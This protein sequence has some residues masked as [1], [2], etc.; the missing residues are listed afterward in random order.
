[1]SYFAPIPDIFYEQF[2][3]DGK[4]PLAGGYIYFYEAGTL[5]PKI[6]FADGLG[7]VTNTN[8]VQLDAGG[9]AVIFLDNGAYKIIIK[10]R[11][12][13]QI[14]EPV[15]NVA[16][17]AGSGTGDAT[18]NITTVLLYAD[19]RNLTS[20][21]SNVYVQGRDTIGD[22]GQ[23]LFQLIPNS[24]LLDD[25]GTILT[26]NSGATVYKRVFDA[27]LEAAWYGVKYSIANDQYNYLNHAL[28]ASKALGYPVM[29]SGSAFLNTNMT[30]I[31]DESIAFLDGA[32]L[33]A[34]QDIVI[35]FKE[36]SHCQAS[37]NC[38]GSHIQPKFANGT[39]D[40]ISPS[41]FSGSGD[42][43]L[44]RANAAQNSTNLVVADPTGAGWGT[45]AEGK[46]IHAPYN[47]VY[48]VST[49]TGLITGNRYKLHIGIDRP[50]DV[51]FAVS[52]NITL[53]AF[54]GTWLTEYSHAA[55][56][57]VMPLLL[58]TKVPAGDATLKFNIACTAGNVT[59][60]FG[61]TVIGTYSA[62]TTYSTA[63]TALDSAS[64]TFTPS[65]TFVGS[66]SG[67]S[68][69]VSATVLNDLVNNMTLISDGWSGSKGALV[70]NVGNT[71]AA[72]LTKTNPVSAGSKINGSFSIS[73]TATEAN[74][75]TN[76]G[77]TLTRWTGSLTGGFIPTVT[78]PPYGGNYYWNGANSIVGTLNITD[79]T[80]EYIV[81]IAVTGN[82]TGSLYAMVG[83]ADIIDYP[84]RTGNIPLANGTYTKT[85]KLKSANNIII[86]A[87]ETSPNS[88]EM[89]PFQGT[90]TLTI[91]PVNP[92]K[93]TLTCDG[94]TITL[95]ND[96]SVVAK[97]AGNYTFEYTT[98]S[99]TSNV[100]AITPTT[101]FDGTI[102]N[103]Q[104]VV[105]DPG[106]LTVGASN[107]TLGTLSKSGAYD[108]YFNGSSIN[109]NISL[110]PSLDFGARIT[111]LT[112]SEA[113]SNIPI[114]Y[115]GTYTIT[116]NIAQGY[117]DPF[118][119]LI[120]VNGA[121]NLIFAGILNNRPEQFLEYNDLSYVGT[122]DLGEAIAY[123]EHAGAV[124]DGSADDSIGLKYALSNSNTFLTNKYRLL[125]AITLSNSLNIKGNATKDSSY[126]D[127]SQIVIE[128]NTTL[129]S[130]KSNGVIWN[131]Q[132]GTAFA[133]SGFNS[134]NSIFAN[135][136]ECSTALGVFNA[137]DST[138]NTTIGL[139]NT[140][141][142]AQIINSEF[143]SANTTDVLQKPFTYAALVKDTNITGY[144]GFTAN[145]KTELD[146]VKFDSDQGYGFDIPANAVVNAKDISAKVP[147]LAL[148]ADSTGT[149]CIDRV[150]DC[151]DYVSSEGA[152]IGDKTTKTNILTNGLGTVWESNIIEPST[153]SGNVPTLKSVINGT[154]IGYVEYSSKYQTR[155]FTNGLNS[156]ND[157]QWSWGM[158]TD[159][160]TLVAGGVQLLGDND[161]CVRSAFTERTNTLLANMVQWDMLTTFG[162]IYKI[163]I[164]SDS[165]GFAKNAAVAIKFT[166]NLSVNTLSTN[167]EYFTKVIRLPHTTSLTVVEV[168]LPFNA[169]ITPSM[170]THPAVKLE[171][172]GFDSM[173]LQF[174]LQYVNV[175]NATINL[176]EH[177]VW[178]DRKTVPYWG[179]ITS[180]LQNIRQVDFAE[181][182]Y[183]QSQ[184]HAIFQITNVETID[185]E[186]IYKFHFWAIIKLSM[187][188][189]IDPYAYRSF[190]WNASNNTTYFTYGDG[191]YVK[192]SPKNPFDFGV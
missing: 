142:T 97:D 165:A 80:T 160:A 15:D 168:D 58:V 110:Q 88:E 23:G 77:W 37:N 126:S 16:S 111:S 35:D 133:A 73:R 182:T 24:S 106:T 40:Y 66:I 91:K 34:T 44:S 185:F 33:T 57:G 60:Q 56:T 112:V 170:G 187:S 141:T 151:L 50:D 18:G 68:L 67:I 117:V 90:V 129:G 156:D 143:E 105:Q 52:N 42:S 155:D 5:V 146:N 12:G 128:A 53:N 162:G 159:Q 21:P 69:L 76:D 175:N 130:V 163:K 138:I 158:T 55:G 191:E 113:S 20:T 63:V 115:T 104:Y 83:D 96:S 59:V 99:T 85:V 172:R 186:D 78:L 144:T 189:L 10:D 26:A 121:A 61:S 3:A 164:T 2:T 49:I 190:S 179:S 127:G 51:E 149:L 148:F 152:V 72:T 28:I 1:M 150:Y 139:T 192:M 157:A 136:Y 31:K 145:A 114:K 13:N 131:Q 65:D 147:M 87:I 54:T 109:N 134:K 122:V 120:I 84:N 140:N 46:Y 166:Y 7:T 41:Y 123:P 82:T 75:L 183:N 27:Y 132:K 137:K 89:Y 11:A 124:G 177:L 174:V 95:N 38:F 103:L 188:T 36:G 79:T 116:G 70:H 30:L 39:I 32:E 176:S 81:S 135:T 167:T 92:G 180:L 71:T 47:S 29:I 93:V 101:D 74:V 178:P 125:S 48:G 184:S 154:A 161:D 108:L 17:S 8:P 14:G 100:I 64:L 153:V 102:N 171:D 22:G 9:K 19:L 4:T 43:K 107:S 119:G 173:D 169:G 98:G 86:K 45:Y 181:A 6:T 62:D 118:N 25:D 94:N